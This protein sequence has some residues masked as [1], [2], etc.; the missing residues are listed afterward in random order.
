MYRLIVAARVRHIFTRLDAGDSET[1]LRSLAPA[2]VYRFYGDHALGGEW[3]TLAAV[4]AWWGRL[5]RL[6]PGAR[7]E[8]RYVLVAGWPWSTRVA[9]VQIADG[10]RRGETA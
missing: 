1:M 7:F 8:P 2:F 3:R 5:F 6:L 9:T 4:R 10:S